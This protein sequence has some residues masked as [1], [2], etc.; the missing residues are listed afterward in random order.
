MAAREPECFLTGD[1]REAY[2]PDINAPGCA[3][4]VDLLYGPR[5]RLADGRRPLDADR[6]ARRHRRVGPDDV[7]TPSHATFGATPP[8]PVPGGPKLK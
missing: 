1:T 6:A 5:L 3:R 4:V 8:G 7:D 2:M